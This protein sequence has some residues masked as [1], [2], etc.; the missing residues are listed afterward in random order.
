VIV[1]G[2]GPVGATA[3]LLLA[4][5]GLEVTIIDQR[6]EPIAHP[7][8]HVISTR[9]LEIFREIGIEALVHADAA[10]LEDLRFIVYATSLTGPELGRV[11]VSEL[12]M[13]LLES[14]DA[15]SPT[16]AA[17]YPQN[18]LERLLWA[19]LDAAPKVRFLRSTTYLGHED[20]ERGVRVD[21]T[22]ADGRFVLEGSWLVAADGASSQVRR[23]LGITMDGP[24][25]QHMISAHIEV[26]TAPY[27][28]GRESPLSWTHT[29]SGIGTFIL[30]RPPG[31]VVFQVPYFPPA[32]RVSD[33]PPERV[34]NLVLK[35]I[36]DPAAEVVVKSVQPWLVTAQIASSYRKGRALLIGDSAHRFP[37]TGGLG[38]NTG[39]ADA[40]NLAWKIAWV[41]QGRADEALLDTYELERRPIAEMNTRHSVMN[42]EGL[43]D[44][45]R[46]LGM[47]GSGNAAI[48]RLAG[49]R[50]VG[51]LPHKLAAGLIRGIVNLGF[52][53]LRL[54]A[55]PGRAGKRIRERAEEVIGRQ[56]PHYRSWGADLGYRYD[57]GAVVPH[58]DGVEPDEMEFY[59]PDVRV[60]GRLPHAEVSVDGR[61]VST[62]DL[63]VLDRMTLLC[64]PSRADDW[65][66][67]E[68][69]QITVVAVSG[70]E[71]LGLAGGR[72]L[73]VRPDQHIAAEVA[74]PDEVL[75]LVRGLVPQPELTNAHSQGENHG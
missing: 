73:L 5:Q 61:L 45:V 56:G 70:A 39:V 2:A 53:R 67:V 20:L 1:V 63:P 64:D 14:I 26:D 9:T 51:W 8:A 69:P 37:P 41:E 10:D 16:R 59:H 11:A 12:P 54:A 50:V 74:D 66:G 33:F 44:V 38:L 55:S 7:A 58:E 46:A 40:H 52:G 42:M 48:S 65:R 35:A 22:G 31:D 3:A 23:G 27:F 24:S 57:R 17:H 13:E 18:R 60:G 68:G 47:P 25:L 21:V 4:R 19:A 32:E 34:K 15:S 49:S 75:P 30:H 43:F 28:V 36:G 62:L 29:P 6:S 72:A 71:V